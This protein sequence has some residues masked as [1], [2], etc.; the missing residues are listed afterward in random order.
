MSVRTATAIT[1]SVFAVVAMVVQIASWRA[2]GSIGGSLRLSGLCA[3]Q[4]VVPSDA[5]ATG[6]I[7][8]GDVVDLRSLTWL[9]RVDILPPIATPTLS[10]AAGD[11]LDI[12][13]ERD[14]RLVVREVLKQSGSLP[15]FLAEAGFKLFFLL[16]G[17]FVLF[18]GRD[19]ASLILG[20]WCFAISFSL[21][22][23][24]FGIMPPFG[25]LWLAMTAIVLW[26]VAPVILYFIIEAVVS[27]LMPQKVLW[28]TRAAL[29]IFLAP[30]FLDL[31]AN[32]LA[33]VR[34]G[35][36]LW[37]IRG[38]DQPLQVANQAIIL[39]FFVIAYARAQGIQ[40][41]RIRWVFWAFLIS[42]F[43]VMMALINRV[44]P[45]PIHLT[46]IEWLTVMV[47]PLGTAYAVLRHKIIDVSFALNR[48]LLYTIL[49]TLTVG[50]F[51]LLEN[52]LNNVAVSRGVSLAVE[53]IVA[54]CIGLSFRALH[55]RVHE[56]INR[57]L[58]RRKHDT[59]VALQRFIDEAPFIQSPETLVA[60]A[61]DEIAKGMGGADVRFYQAYVDG[62]HRLGPA[63]AAT[64]LIDAD[65][66]AL[67]RLRSTQ[68][69]VDLSSIQS[70]MGAVG[71]AFPLFVRGE[72]F[73]VLVCGRRADDEGYTPDD[74]DL[75]RH[76]AREVAAE[77]FIIRARDQRDLLQA[78][79][80]GLIDPD[81]A[82]QRARLLVERP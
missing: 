49:T 20:V 21:P 30:G 22:S 77:L 46:G 37:A 47:F 69:E 10:G 5:E 62:Y 59:S 50:L 72:N 60:R 19:R 29:L 24:W 1:L 42:R 67:I 38:V 9:A 40:R 71:F 13:I 17:A 39:I 57:L 52:L 31:T 2:T 36:G 51:V 81:K 23:A 15:G 12:P 64:E 70:A 41:Q 34:S 80:S 76:V 53:I 7:R 44:V 66:P 11:V 54:L 58:F 26:L 82:S 4:F 61:T 27:G 48:A 63:G 33:Q 68:R 45:H 75:L 43:G 28:L 73:G 18:R 8:P 6:G 56:W 65:D 74:R 16:I 25:R 3:V 78:I 79:A 35:C 14:G 55:G 32:L